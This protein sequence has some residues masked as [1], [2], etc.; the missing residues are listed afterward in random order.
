MNLYTNSV[1]LSSEMYEFGTYRLTYEPP[2]DALESTIDMSISSEADLSKM[3]SL[4]GDFLRAAGYPI[5]L[6]YELSVERKSPDFGSPQ[7]FWVDDGVSWVGN[8]WGVTYGSSDQG[9]AYIGSGLKGGMGDDHL[10]FN[11]CFGSNVVTFG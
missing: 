7:E 1:K 2:Q 5:D 4:F 11:S 3:L 10:S 6:D 9:I 8:P